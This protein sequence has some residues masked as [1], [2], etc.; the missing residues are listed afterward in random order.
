MAKE[1][2]VNF[3]PGSA[4]NCCMFLDQ[5]LPLGCFPMQKVRSL[6]SLASND[7][8]KTLFKRYFSCLLG[9]LSNM[10]PFDNPPSTLRESGNFGAESFFLNPSLFP[11]YLFL[12]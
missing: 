6:D 3:S 9:R 4:T 2:E 11:C 12:N 5:S 1:R 8:H 7:K 10:Q